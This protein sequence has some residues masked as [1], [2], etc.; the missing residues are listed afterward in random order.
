MSFSGTNRHWFII[1]AEFPVGLCLASL[2][3]ELA[4]P[5]TSR[6][7]DSREQLSLPV[8]MSAVPLA[9][10]AVSGEDTENAGHIAEWI[11][12]L[13]EQ[14]IPLVLLSSAKVFDYNEVGSLESDEV[15]GDPLLIALENQ[16]R[17]QLRHLILRV[18]QPFSLLTGDYA[19]NLLAAARS[20]DCLTLDNLIRIAPTPVDDIAD[21]IHA[22]LQQI[23]CDETLWGTYHYCSVESTTEYGFAEVLLAEARQYEDLAHVSLEE[24]ADEDCQPS[25]TILDSKLIKHTFGIKPKPWRQALSR[26]MR[27]YY[28][29]DEKT[30]S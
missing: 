27:R 4:L 2:A 24:K 9:I 10:I 6:R 25:E 29:A 20:Q 12:L 13:I 22:L 14:D 1:G 5:Y 30:D 28:R 21:V 16:A 23:S 7:L 15:T 3:S 26:L 8:G 17:K 18:N 11:D 19:V